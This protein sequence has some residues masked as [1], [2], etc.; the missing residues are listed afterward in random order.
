M[1]LYIRKHI[2][3]QQLW[4]FIFFGEKPISFQVLQHLG[5]LICT[6]KAKRKLRTRP[7]KVHFSRQ[8]SHMNKTGLYIPCSNIFSIP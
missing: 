8:L 7:I 5:I 2:Y 1:N 4:I 3:Q 6:H